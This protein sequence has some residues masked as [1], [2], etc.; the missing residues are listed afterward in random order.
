MGYVRLIW[1]TLAGVAVG[2][3]LMHPFAMLAYTLGPQSPYAPMEGSS[4]KDSWREI[5]G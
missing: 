2:Y 3:L 1:F 4:G 5:A